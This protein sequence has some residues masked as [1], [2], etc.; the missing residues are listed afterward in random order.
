MI[1]VTGGTGFIGQ[2]LVRSLTKNGEKIVVADTCESNLC[3][4]VNVEFVRADI[5]EN[6][7]LSS[8]EAKYSVIYHCAGLAN[9]HDSVTRPG[10]TFRINT[11]GTLN[12]LEFAR[13]TRSG[14]FILLSSVSVFDIGNPLPLSETSVKR[15]SSPYGASKLAAEA[16]CQAWSKTYHTDTRIARIFNTYGIGQ[17]AL[18]IHDIVSKILRCSGTLDFS[19]TGKQI[20]DYVY[21]DDLTAALHMIATGG[22]AGEDYNICS[23]KPVRLLDLVQL[24]LELMNK[25]DLRIR[26]SGQPRK[27]DI[28]KWYGDPSKLASLGF[29]PTIDIE[30]G[31]KISLPYYLAKC[32][33]KR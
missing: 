10:L 19:G 16:F 32:K 15:A 4:S 26:V 24:I 22:K 21:I 2:N 12:M 31:L 30:T 23:G 7:Q 28:E 29:I 11:Q 18:F 13:K 8:L 6:R 20:R 5:L 14:T 9:V 27:G 17:T 3:P 25:K 1:L 33:E